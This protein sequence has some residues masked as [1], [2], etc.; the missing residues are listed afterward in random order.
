MQGRLGCDSLPSSMFLSDYTLFSDF[1]MEAT[2][3]SIFTYNW[4][5][6]IAG[7]KIVKALKR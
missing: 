3:P 6:C 7:Q 4:D 1:S 2:S 5:I